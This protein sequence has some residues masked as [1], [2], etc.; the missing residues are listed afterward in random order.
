MSSNAA[1]GYILLKGVEGFKYKSVFKHLVRIGMDI[2]PESIIPVPR[3]ELMNSCSHFEKKFNHTLQSDQSV[4][5]KCDDEEAASLHEKEFMLLEGIDNPEDRF[6]AFAAGL[7]EFGSSLAPGS[8]VFVATNGAGYAAQNLT[9][10]TVHYIGEV[11]GY[12]GTQFGVELKVS[13]LTFY[14]AADLYNKEE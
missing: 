11:E 8:K 14:L 13:M 12:P 2:S 4:F 7:V 9:R 1:T 5:L 10:A 3:G 6:S